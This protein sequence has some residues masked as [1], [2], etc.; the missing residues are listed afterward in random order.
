[1]NGDTH[2]LNSVRPFLMLQM[3]LRR[4]CPPHRC[5]YLPVHS[6]GAYANC[7]RLKAQRRQRCADKGCSRKFVYPRDTKCPP[8]LYHP[9]FF[10]EDPL[11]SDSD[12]ED[13]RP[14]PVKAP[15]KGKGKGRQAA[16]ETWPMP[17]P[18]SDEHGNMPPLD[19]NKRRFI[20][21]ADTYLKKSKMVVPSAKIEGVQKLIREWQE[22]APDDKIISKGAPVA[23]LTSYVPGFS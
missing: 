11:D 12:S 1:M 7:D 4:S 18:G 16:M 5:K 14:M 8:S 23:L 15:R 13:E 17:S 19:N 6:L 20:D 3:C 10:G 2:Y 9:M 22:T 21:F